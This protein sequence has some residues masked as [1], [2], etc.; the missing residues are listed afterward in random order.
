MFCVCVL[1]RWT[2][3]VGLFAATVEWSCPT[4]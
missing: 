2:T 3:T 1:I 4:V